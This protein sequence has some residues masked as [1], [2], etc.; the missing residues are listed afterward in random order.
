TGVFE[1]E[2]ASGDE[3]LDGPRHQDLRP[4]CPGGDP[5]ADRDREAAWLAVDDLALPYVPPGA[6]LDSEARDRR[7]DLLRA[8]D[9]A[10]GPDEAREEPVACGVVLGSLPVRESSAHDG[11]MFEHELPPAPVPALC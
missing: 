10:R 3:I 4:A 2:P 6:G 1:P 7:R 11:V 9:S 5:G 8:V